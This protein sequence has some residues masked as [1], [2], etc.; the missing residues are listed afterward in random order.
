MPHHLPPR[1]E[2]Q[3]IGTEGVLSTSDPWH[4]SASRID[5]RRPDGTAETITVT[6]QDSYRLELENFGAATRGTAEPLLGRE[7]AL[8]QARTIEALYASAAADGGATTI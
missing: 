7:D 2:L 4:C 5:I 8:G 3:A 1:R 6:P